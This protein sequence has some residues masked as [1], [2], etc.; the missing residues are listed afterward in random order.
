[1]TGPEIAERLRAAFPG[2]LLETKFEEKQSWMR[3]NPESIERTCR[4]LHDEPDLAFDSLMCLS[5]VD[6]PQELECVYHLYSNRH[7]HSITLKAGV[8]KDRTDI[9]T[10]STVW[11]GADWFEREAFDLVGI[12]FSGHPDLRRIMMPEDWVGHPLRKDYKEPA[13]Y[14]GIQTA[15]FFPTTTGKGVARAAAAGGHGQP[16]DEARAAAENSGKRE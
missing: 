11:K 5:G 15:R 2:A 3:V 7:R 12:R 14:L 13:E 6:R 16:N 8:P 10:V 9:P 1:M 4:F